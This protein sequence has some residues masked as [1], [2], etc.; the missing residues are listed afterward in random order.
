MS[1]PCHRDDRATKIEARSAGARVV[2]ATL[3]S[4]CDETRLPRLRRRH[5]IAATQHRS[6]TYG[7]RPAPCTDGPDASRRRAACARSSPRVATPPRRLTRD[8]AGC[9]AK[10]RRPGALSR[11]ERR[12]GALIEWGVVSP[13]WTAS[14]TAAWSASSS[15]SPAR[16][17]NVRGTLVTGIGPII[18]RSTG[19]I[20]P[21]CTCTS[22]ELV[23]RVGG[24]QRCATRFVTTPSSPHSPPA[25][26]CDTTAC[27]SG[28]PRQ[29]QQDA[30]CCA[31]VGPSH[32]GR[33]R[34]ENSRSTAP[35]RLCAAIAAGRHP[36]ATASW[37][38]TK[39]NRPVKILRT[40]LSMEQW[41]SVS[42]LP[43]SNESTG[44]CQATPQGGRRGGGSAPA[45]CLGP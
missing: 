7:H 25:L 35:P 6:D 37:V 44:V 14:S 40:S 16:S 45:G 20:T 31:E 19:S 9:S 8:R 3:R 18:R 1:L 42:G 38:V 4:E 29:P 22:S 26:A 27:V 41:G 36:R 21:R 34:S 32:R 28:P 11:R 13:R 15:S 10:C 23:C 12:A 39:P 33:H 2:A 43:C 24:T 17:I 30:A 5:A